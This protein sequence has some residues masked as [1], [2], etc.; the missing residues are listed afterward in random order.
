[1]GQAKLIA[2]STT[3]LED[4]A[5]LCMARVQGLDAVNITQASLAVGGL[6]GKSIRMDD[7]TIIIGLTLVI[8][9]NIFDALQTDARWTV[10]ALGYNF[11]HIVPASALSAGAKQYS[12]EYI[13][14]DTNGDTFPV[15]F[16]ITT[17]PIL[18]S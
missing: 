14:T 10:D 5:A 4:G 18:T 9:T 17:K 1:M 7:P 2:A 11:R 8:T 13:F 16:E 12:V 15:V 6:T 3:V